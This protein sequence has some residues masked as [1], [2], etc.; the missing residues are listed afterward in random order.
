[1][2]QTIIHILKLITAVLIG[3]EISIPPNP[4]KMELVICLIIVIC[5]K[6]DVP[7]RISK[8]L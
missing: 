8:H 2:K 7:N 3:I 4:Y 5:L 6:Y 1:M